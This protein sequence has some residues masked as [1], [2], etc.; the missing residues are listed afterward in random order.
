M[1]SIPETQGMGK[2]EGE[3][4]G[5]GGNPGWDF[6]QSRGHFSASGNQE[7]TKVAGTPQDPLLFLELSLLDTGIA[8]ANLDI[9]S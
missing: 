4:G 5:T 3:G 1:Y 7:M 2:T 9:S 8:V 6:K